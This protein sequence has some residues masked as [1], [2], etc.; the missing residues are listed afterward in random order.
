MFKKV[1]GVFRKGRTW[2]YAQKDVDL[3]LEKDEVLIEVIKTPV[4][5]SDVLIFCN[6]YKE[7]LQV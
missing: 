3:S 2:K 5:L 7:S 1:F 4:N 6:K